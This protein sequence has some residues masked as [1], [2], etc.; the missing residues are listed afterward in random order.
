MSQRPSN[1]CC[2]VGD[3]RRTRRR[4]GG[5]DP[6]HEC[7]LPTGTIGCGNVRPHTGPIYDLESSMGR[8]R[9]SH[10]RSSYFQAFSRGS[11]FGA[12]EMEQRHKGKQPD[13]GAYPV[14]VR[15]SL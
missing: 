15:A 3:E 10:R 1:A 8:Q 14:E 2:C 11:R 13:P 9:V 4:R 12:Q 6:P 5:S 7:R